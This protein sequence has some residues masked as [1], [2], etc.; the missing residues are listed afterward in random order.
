MASGL[1]FVVQHHQA[2]QDHYDFRLEWEGVLLSWAV[3]KGPSLNSRDKRLAVRVEDHPLEYRKFEGTIP[4][5]EYGAGAVMIWDEGFWEPLLDVAEGLEKGSLKFRLAGRRLKG[6]WAL[7]RFRTAEDEGANWLLIKEKDDYAREDAGIASCTTSIRTGRTMDEIASGADVIPAS[8]PFRKA[9]VQLAKLAGKVPDGDGWIYELKYDGY[10]ILAFLEDG[11][12]RLVTRNNQDFTQHF[13]V[14]ADSLLDWSGSRAMVLDGEIVV[15][16]KHGK[17]DFQ[18]LQNYFRDPG[19]KTLVYVIFDILALDGKDLRPEPLNERKQKLA[20]LLENAPPGLH[21][22]GHSGGSGQELLQSACQAGMEGIVCKRSGS[23]YLGNRNDDWLKVKCGNRQEFVIGGYTLT[24]EKKSGL[25]ALL[26][27][28]YAGGDL[29]YA[30]RAG[31]GFTE[32]TV[33]DLASRFSTLKRKTPPFKD[34]PESRK[35]EVITWLNPVLVAEINFAEWTSD[36]LLRQASFKGLRT[37]KDPREVQRETMKNLDLPD[38]PDRPES[39]DPPPA[40][41]DTAGYGPIHLTHPEK[42]LLPG[43]SKEDLVRYYAAVSGRMLPL[44]QNRILNFLRCPDGIGGQCFYQK[45]LEISVPGIRKITVRDTSGREDYYYIENLAG[46][47]ATAQMDILEIHVWNSRVDQLDQPD[48]IVFD[49]D[50]E[51]GMSL[52][53][54]RQGVRDMKEVLDELGLASFLKTSGGKG[55]HVVIP[56]EPAADW[57]AIRDFAHLV[58]EAMEQRWPGR[59]TSNLRKNRRIGKI[60][61]DWDRNIRG[62]TSIAPYSLRAR[63]GAPV[64]MPILWEDLEKVEPGSIK[65]EDAIKRM[66]DLD[67]WQDFY[68]V[69]QH[70]KGIQIPKNRR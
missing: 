64:A 55:Y 49:L 51:E 19:G 41:P 10:R 46:L 50:P 60:F 26:L 34:P 62:A 11:S 61:I 42:E 31:T 35:G 30:G 59:Y 16:D 58:A 28:Y 54:V 43:L 66:T 4:E 33:L 27:G 18:A 13:Q 47:L 6:S 38:P 37:D 20:E 57:N 5:K 2:R 56:L 23:A 24:E 67:P 68:K 48:M 15:P 39:P 21:F 29:I 40:S 7:V 32:K 45:H 22:G 12:A 70:I 1:H 3:P 63:P 69:K 36:N 14:I 52:A 25:S 17:T 53:G 9:D 44:V 8:N 65:I